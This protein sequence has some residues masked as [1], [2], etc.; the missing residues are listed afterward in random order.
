MTIYQYGRAAWV[1]RVLITFGMGAGGI[2]TAV[3]V[4]DYALAPLLTALPLLAPSVYF[5][6]VLAV[7][8]DVDGNVL[9]VWTLA[10][11]RRTIALDRIRPGTV[12]TYAQGY[13]GRIYAPRVFV[14]VR[15]GL[16]IY[17]DLLAT[18]PDE[19]R[20]FDALRLPRP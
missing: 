9:R 20:F 19:R 3:A 12:R 4:R 1:W 17:V 6:Y 13:S 5:G 7:R 10:F 2:L 16:A 14:P 15:G 18:I 8:I 11:A